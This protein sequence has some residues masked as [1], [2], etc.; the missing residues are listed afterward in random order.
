LVAGGPTTSVMD[1]SNHKNDKLLLFPNPA[2]G[3]FIVLYESAENSNGLLNIIDISGREVSSK[4]IN[5]SIGENNFTENTSHL[6]NGIY[7]VQLK[8]TS[9]TI[10]KKLVIAK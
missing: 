8:T 3:D 7:L 10:T 4:N 5:L 9:Q 6:Q 1:L 2:S